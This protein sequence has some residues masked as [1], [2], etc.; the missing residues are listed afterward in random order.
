VYENYSTRTAEIKWNQVLY[1]NCSTCTTGIKW[2]HVVY[3]NCGTR[4]TEIK[5]DH[6]VMLKFPKTGW[7]QDSIG[8]RDF[9]NRAQGTYRLDGEYSSVNLNVTIKTCIKTEPVEENMSSTEETNFSRLS[10]QILF[11]RTVG[12][13]LNFSCTQIGRSEDR[14]PVEER[15]SAPV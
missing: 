3:E 1:E 8:T 15:F 6:V 12:P 7:V 5:W 10:V 4:T 11:T 9:E 13:S 14:I 2:D